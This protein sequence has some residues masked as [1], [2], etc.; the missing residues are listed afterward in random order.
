MTQIPLLHDINLKIFTYYH[1]KCQTDESDHKL[2]LKYDFVCDK[3]QKGQRGKKCCIY[4]IW[5]QAI[6]AWGNPQG[7]I[8]RALMFNALVFSCSSYWRFSRN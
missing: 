7:E 1:T 4:E 3:K 5:A 6:H 8:L 2:Y